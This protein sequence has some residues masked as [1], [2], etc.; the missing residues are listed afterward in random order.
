V[1][2]LSVDRVIIKAKT[3]VKKGEIAEAEKLYHS[4]LKVFPENRKAK[5][6]LA[7][8]NKAEQNFSNK[9]PPQ[10]V[11]SELVSLIIKDCSSKSSNGR[12]LLQR[13]TQIRL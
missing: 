5:K 12:K 10:G 13:S 6:G 7:T 2:K 1:G 3:H 4:V 8:L 9:N 11:V